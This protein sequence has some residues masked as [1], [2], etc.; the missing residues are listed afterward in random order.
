MD[1]EG[2]VANKTAKNQPDFVNIK[3]YAVNGAVH[4]SNAVLHY[5]SYTDVIAIGVTGY[6]AANGKIKHLIGV[7]YVSKSNFGVGQRVDD[8][9]DLSFLKKE[10][11]SAFIE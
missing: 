2:N 10:H 7:Y 6:K 1:E 3:A 9:T 11:F 8:Y 5:T 4:Y